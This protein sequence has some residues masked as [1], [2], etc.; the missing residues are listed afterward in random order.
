MKKLSRVL[1]IV[2]PTASNHYAMERAASLCSKSGATLDLLICC[3]NE[4]LGGQRF[5]D[6]PSLEKARKQLMEEHLQYLEALARPL[7]E[8]GIEVAIAI[9]WDRPLHEGIARYA[10]TINADLVIK[11]TH[12]HSAISNTLMGNTDWQL[13]RCCAAPLW[14]VKPVSMPDRPIFLSALDPMNEHDKPAALDDEILISAKKI[15][16][17]Y[18]GE[19][20]AFHA[21]DPRAALATVTANAYLPVSLPYDE[22]EQQMR[23]DHGRRLFEITKYHSIADDH[24]HLVAGRTEEEL[25][26]LAS[27]LNA[28]VVVMGAIART[29]LKRL[30]IG[31]TAER[32]LDRLPCD[33]LIIKPDWFRTPAAILHHREAAA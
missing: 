3:Y 17:L 4:Y 32:T 24:T 25:S 11:D 33:L 6:S 21:Y 7:Q 18:G 8:A 9:H 12:F 10:A 19:V 20:H 1:C 16:D 28:A 5:F 31:S 29:R 23:E 30:F 2:D 13:I 26:L 15:A 14:L 27:K 22:I